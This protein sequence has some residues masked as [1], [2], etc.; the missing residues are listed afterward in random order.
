MRATKQAKRA[1][2]QLFRACLINGLLDDNR[3][4][5]VV[6]QVIAAKPRGYLGTLA[7]FKRLVELDLPVTRR[8]R[9]RP[10]VC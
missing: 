2:T 4:R 9:S 8:Q 3:A 1:A 7:Y 10:A 5:K 6:E